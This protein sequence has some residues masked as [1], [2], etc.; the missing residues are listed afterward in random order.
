MNASKWQT[1]Y[2]LFLLYSP[3]NQGLKL[4]EAKTA[5][6]YASGFLLYSPLNQGLKHQRRI[7]QMSEYERFLLY[8]PLNQ[9]LKQAYPRRPDNPGERFY[10][11]V[12]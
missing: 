4:I 11:T 8:S 2:E 5:N 3:L 9:G 6:A 10:S 1:P 12:H 7:D